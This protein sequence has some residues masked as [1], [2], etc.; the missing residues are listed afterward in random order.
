MIAVLPASFSCSAI[1]VH[2]KPKP[3]GSLAASASISFKAA[4]SSDAYSGTASTEM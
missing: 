4:P 1:S 2:S 3:S